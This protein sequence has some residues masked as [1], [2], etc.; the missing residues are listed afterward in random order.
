MDINQTLKLKEI[1]QLD[2]A[3]LQFSRNTL[4]TKRICASVLVAIIAII[5]RITDNKLDVSIYIASFITLLI[6]WIIDSN[7][8]YYQRLLRKRMTQIVNELKE[9]KFIN[10]GF[11]M[12]LKKSEKIN[13]YNSMF[14]NSQLFYSLSL[15]VIICI[16]ICDYICELPLFVSFPRQ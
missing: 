2:A 12:P 1:D 5:L 11:D 4:I 8:Y 15:L 10:L 16:S 9:D 13:W 14:N 6:F 3:I 7:S